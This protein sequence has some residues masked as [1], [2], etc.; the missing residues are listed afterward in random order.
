MQ[1]TWKNTYIHSKH[2]WLFFE[3]WWLWI[4]FPIFI[5]SKFSLLFLNLKKDVANKNQNFINILQR[6][7]SMNTNMLCIDSPIINTLSH[8]AII[9][10]FS[11]SPYTHALLNYF[12]TGKINFM[13]HLL[14]CIHTAGN[15][16]LILFIKLWIFMEVLTPE[17]L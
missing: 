8:F 3:L 17:S 11:L 13:L 1:P 6:Q 14:T 16:A 7:N 15:C 10:I 5:I 2:W 4:F 9:Y 12:Q